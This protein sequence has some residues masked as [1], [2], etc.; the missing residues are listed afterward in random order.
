MV[1]QGF[2]LTRDGRTWVV[3]DPM[4]ELVFRGERRRALCFV[5]ERI[6]AWRPV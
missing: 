6:Q 1:C 3:R 5:L 2:K 4:G